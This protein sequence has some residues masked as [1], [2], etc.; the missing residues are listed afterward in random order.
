MIR[1]NAKDLAEL[2]AQLELVFQ[3]IVDL[4]GGR[5]AGFEA[6]ARSN[7]PSSGWS[8]GT[9]PRDEAQA[10]FLTRLTVLMLRRGAAQLGHWRALTPEAHCWKLSL[11]LPSI[12]LQ[13]Q[14]LLDEIS[15]LRNLHGLPEG[16]LQLELSEHAV[17]PDLAAACYGIRAIQDAGVSVSL[18]DFGAGATALRWLVELP[19]DGLK[20]DHSLVAAWRQSERGRLVLQAVL[21]L[22]LKLALPAVAEGVEDEETRALLLEWGCPLGQGYFFAPPLTGE[23]VLNWAV[24]RSRSLR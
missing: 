21:D 20:L 15:T 17:L 23:A 16:V 14:W 10:V 11:N 13:Q 5:V 3:P 2:N 19:F 9:Q 12:D 7:K 24:D 22:A 18:D 4:G 1:M 6:L 8:L